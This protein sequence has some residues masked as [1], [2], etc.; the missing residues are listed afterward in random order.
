MKRGTIERFEGSWSSGLATLVFQDGERV[1]C[2]NGPTARAL[3]AAFG[4]AGGGHT[5]DN[6]RLRGKEVYWE[7]D[8]M[9]L[10]LGGLVAVDQLTADEVSKLD[11]VIRKEQ[12]TR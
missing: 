3:I 6:R 12:T 4:C 2:D 11:E 5:I 7:W 8:D 9:G 10:V 1:P